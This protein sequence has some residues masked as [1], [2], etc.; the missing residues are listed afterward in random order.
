MHGSFGE[1]LSHNVSLSAFLP[2]L[3]HFVDKNGINI[4]ENHFAVTI[5]QHPYI[6]AMLSAVQQEIRESLPT[7]IAFKG[8]KLDKKP[9]F[10]VGDTGGKFPKK[11][12]CSHQQLKGI[13]HGFP[14]VNRS[15][16]PRNEN[17]YKCIKNTHEFVASLSAEC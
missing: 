13:R 8:R 12:F 3:F 2:H 14:Q 5:Q 4:A 6:H 17:L 11:R 10:A 1:N 7:G 15:I 16:L 9:G